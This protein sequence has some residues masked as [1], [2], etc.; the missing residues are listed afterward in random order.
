MR[1]DWLL[2]DAE[3][4][5]PC[6]PDLELTDPDYFNYILTAEGLLPDSFFK[7]DRATIDLKAE[8]EKIAG[9]LKQCRD[10]RLLCL[11]ARFR[12]LFGQ[13]PEFCDCLI[14]VARLLEAHWDEVYP[15]G[16][17]GDYMLR[18]GAIGTLEDIKATILPLEFAPIVTDRRHGPITFRAQRVARG[19]VAAREGEA[20]LDSGTINETLAAAD[21]GEQV[22]RVFESING[23]RRALAEIR[24]VFIDRSGYEQAPSFEGLEGAL[25]GVGELIATARPDLQRAAEPETTEEA[26]PQAQ[27]DAPAEAVEAGGDAT[28]VTR[29][30]VVAGKEISSNAQA[31]TALLAA[32][33]YFVNK[34]PSNPALILIHQ[35]HSLVGKSFV[36][37]MQ[38]LV[39]GAVDGARLRVLTDKD[40]KL[41]IDQM[42]SL[43]SEALQ[44]FRTEEP[45]EQDSSGNHNFTANIRQEAVALIRGV[46]QFFRANEPSSPVPM[47]LARARQYLNMD[48]EVIL[49]DL[50]P[51]QEPEQSS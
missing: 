44:M 24:S 5:P 19:D 39:P 14:A 46:E 26:A 1:Y 20:E 37:A 50:L 25:A 6:G 13:I 34:E 8:T 18:S 41:N 3:E 45:A 42:R 40:L 48:F 16:E 12:I 47:L 17:E 10:V 23:A 43:S 30:V 4:E 49:A 32:A 38:I 9:Y 28:V 21:H 22:A 33:T 15:R 11:E 7:F 29:T 35:A 27:E 31:R 2:E 51:R 36:D